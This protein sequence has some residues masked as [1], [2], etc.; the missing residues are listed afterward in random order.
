M[1][2]PSYVQALWTCIFTTYID[3]HC[4]IPLC[5]ETGVKPQL[6]SLVDPLKQL[7]LAKEYEDYELKKTLI[8]ILTTLSCDQTAVKIMISKKILRSFLSFVIR[9]DKA[10]GNWTKAQFEELQLLVSTIIIVGHELFFLLCTYSSCLL[11]PGSVLPV[12]S[13][14]PVY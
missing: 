4:L 12:H 10:V 5:T 9:N 11:F 3:T 8:C 7:K 1:K 14:S 13:W 2:I 6:Q